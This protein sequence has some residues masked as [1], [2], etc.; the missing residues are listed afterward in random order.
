MVAS[1]RGTQLILS[2][3]TRVH[4]H[5]HRSP[6]G[7]RCHSPCAGLATVIRL[8]A[9]IANPGR[10][11]RRARRARR[12]RPRA[13]RLRPRARGLV[14]RSRRARGA[15]RSNSTPRARVHGRRWGEAAPGA[16]GQRRFQPAPGTAKRR[17]SFRTRC[18][19]RAATRRNHGSVGAV[20]AAREGRLQHPGRARAALPCDRSPCESLGAKPLACRG[21]LPAWG[22]HEHAANWR[23][24]VA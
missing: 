3:V 20:V 10:P 21:A 14:P 7:V 23:L 16:R 18:R 24:V 12:L 2:K 13:R 6:R 8:V 15:P 17:V 9:Q 5:G 11:A 22:K 1:G 19:H 4:L